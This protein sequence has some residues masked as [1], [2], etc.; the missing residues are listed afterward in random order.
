MFHDKDIEG[1]FERDAE[2]PLLRLEGT[3]YFAAAFIAGFAIFMLH[4]QLRAKPADEPTQQQQIVQEME[5]YQ[6]LEPENYEA[7]VWDDMQAMYVPAVSQEKFEPKKAKVQDY[8]GANVNPA[9]R[10]PKAS[11]KMSTLDYIQK[12]KGEARKHQRQYGIPASIKMAQ[13]IV[14][15]ASGNSG[16]ARENNNHFGV[17]CFSRTCGKGHCTN[18]YDDHHKD[19]F[20]KYQDPAESWKDHSEKLKNNSR[21]AKLFKL[22][23]TDYKG[24]ARGLKA[25]GYATDKSYDTALIRTIETYQLYVLDK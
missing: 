18:K 19:F 25:A 7:V 6:E 12:Y 23:I 5:F 13:A 16:L 4:L 14:E 2:L 21:Y 22:H 10:A 8:T 20:R 1:K 9:P 11:E 15:S 24:W 17:K 3:G